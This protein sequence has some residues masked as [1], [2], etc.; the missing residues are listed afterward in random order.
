MHRFECL[1][2]LGDLNKSVSVQEDA[3]HLTPEGHPD[4]PLQLNNLGGSLMCRFEYLGDLGDLNKSVSVREDAV[5]LTPQGHPDKPL[6]L[7]NLGGS[8]MH[9]FEHLGD[10]GDLNKSVSLQEDAVHLTPDGHPNK[11]LQL[12][13]LG[14]AL[15]KRFKCFKNL[16]D[17]HTS[18]L[19]LSSAACSTTCSAHVRFD[20]SNMWA[21]YTKFQEDPLGAFNAFSVAIDLLPELAWLGLSIQ[22]RHYHLLEASELV[23]HAAALAIALGHLQQA[24]Q[25]L[26]QGRSI[27]WNQLLNLRTPLDML[28]NSYPDLAQQLFSLSFQLEGSGTRV[29]DLEP[30]QSGMHQSPQSSANQAHQNALARE[31]L[32]QKIRGLKGFE[33]FLLPKTISELSQAAQN[34][35][36]VILNIICDRCDALIVIPGLDGDVMHVPLPTLKLTDIESMA[37]SL[38]HLV[39]GTG[40]LGGKREGQM[41][42]EEEFAQHLSELWT[43]IV[44]PVLEALAMVVS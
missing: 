19:H 20:A 3:V 39:R 17:L 9:R 21:T 23:R 24:V 43:G 22:D 37:H 6:L 10:L 41:N 27:I 34:G 32:L 11:P 26:E 28:S 14:Y 15:F 36:V 30:T 7:N 33:R 8:L 2:D 18:V 25:W 12:K 35:P 29:T 44:K 16:A 42:P 1:H 31:K 13:N 5:H 4:K 38:S 40:R